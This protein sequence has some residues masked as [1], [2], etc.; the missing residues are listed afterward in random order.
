MKSNTFKE[1]AYGRLLRRLFFQTLA[2]LAI[3]AILVLFLRSILRGKLADKLVYYIAIFLDT[4]W[5]RAQNIY[6]IYIRNNIE[7]IIGLVI[8]IFFVILFR[9]SSSLFTRYFDQMVAGVDKLSEEADEKIVMNPEL[10]FME[11]K[12]N[13]VKD[14]LKKRAEEAQAAEERKDE[15]V[16]YLAHDIKTPLTSVIGYL[17]L[18][19][20]AYDMPGEQKA[21]YVHI[22]LEKSYRLETLINEFFEIT[23]YNLKSMPLYQKE[24]NLCYMMIQ[25][26]DEL[27][28]QLA[29]HGQDIRISIGENTIIWGDSQKLAR[30][31]NNILKNAIA[32]GDKNSSID[33]SAE[34]SGD[35]VV[36][37]FEN[38]GAIPK[39][40]L[41]SIFEKFY[42]L[43]SA[44]SSTTGGA[45]L[46]LAIAKD[47][48]TLHGGTIKAQSDNAHTIFTVELFNKQAEAAQL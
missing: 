13:E 46:G 17:S 33:I 44:R 3:A 6:F 40:K 11:I 24:I 26:A 9:L 48:I 34:E 30:V 37:C 43:D 18:L 45:G 36:I 1:K 5:Y 7:L 29:P 22:A 31:F 2:L 4:D 47:I 12:L 28:P 39:E 14:R 25:V 21:K 27:Y 38:Q 35:K 32:Y 8:V 23:R 42:R 41:N 16:V 15:L 19:D 20:E 10:R